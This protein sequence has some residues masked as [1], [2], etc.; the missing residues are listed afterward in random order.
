MQELFSNYFIPHGHCYLWKPGLVSLHIISD[1]AISLAYFLI[2]IEL[3]FIVKKRQDI[4]FDWVFMLF[5]SFIICCGIT[6][7]MEI[8]TLW[9]P[10]Y[11]I[12]G[13]LKAI[14]AA[15]SLCT[16]AVI[17]ELIP[18]VLAI[19]SSTQLEAANF[20]LQ[21]EISERKQTQ[22]AL[23]QL[24][25]ELEARVQQRTLDLERT[26]QLLQQENQE[27][28]IAQ[29][30]LKASEIKLR[31]K[32]DKLANTLQELKHTQ[33]QL[34]QTEKMSS[35]GQMVAGVAH[36][37]NNPVNFIY[38][39]IAPTCEYVENLLELIHKYQNYHPKPNPDIENYIQEIDLNF[40]REDINNILKSIRF[41]AERI[42]DIV[43]S[44][45]T[46]SRLDEAEMKV[47]N[48]HE[49]IDSTLMILQHRLKEQSQGSE[50]KLIKDYQD[51]PR[52]ECY[53]GQLNQVFMNIFSNAIDALEERRTQLKNR[54]K[55]RSPEIDIVS[56]PTLWI[57]TTLI[58]HQWV[59][60]H[61]E[62]NGIGMSSEMINKIY[63][64]FYT[65]KP[66]GYG[67]GLGLAISYQIVN[68]HRGYLYCNSQ[69]ERGT[70]FI[71]S[72]PLSTSI[73]Q[74]TIPF[75]TCDLRQ[76][77]LTSGFFWDSQPRVIN[78]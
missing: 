9:H 30:A 6:H 62:D 43:K 34:I 35:L 8:W 48:I 22:V 69:L 40:I 15:I 12:S 32:A 78:H 67:T 53:C 65:T 20:A 18:K 60:I 50:I 49:G 42:K 5:G 23:N 19:P 4:P 68:N 63:D 74:A 57:R 47:V 41:G 25:T 56:P 46:F 39:N 76:N 55:N 44:L 7:I 10:H 27:R 45:R 29:T 1:A 59:Q 64:P 61:I 31:Q 54:V 73:Q 11:W 52:V 77:P 14:T 70:E 26:N 51:L 37:I 66:V 36:E 33:A 17:I 72:I 71:I 38:G 3:I 24:A 75:P 13:F 2:P 16:A 58:N 28:D 21:A